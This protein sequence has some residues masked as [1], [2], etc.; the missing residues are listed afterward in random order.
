MKLTNLKDYIVEYQKGYKDVLNQLIY[1][2]KV[3]ETNGYGETDLVDRIAY[4][5]KKLN[6]FFFEICAEHKYIDNK[7]IEEW[8]FWMER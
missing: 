2:K 4:R 7:D 8:F 6:N 5:D 1:M 3:R